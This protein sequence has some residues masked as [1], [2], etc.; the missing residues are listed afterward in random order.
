MTKSNTKRTSLLLILDGWG[1]REE[2]DSNA[3]AAA[4]TPTWDALW[5]A[6]PHT[7][8]TTSGMAVGLPEGQMGNSEVGHMNLGAGRV[9]YQSLT[10]I[11]KEIAEGGFFRNPVLVDVTQK[12]AT[13]GKALHLFGLLSPGGIHSHEQHM[14]AMIQLA[15]QQG[16]KKVYLHAFLDG[17]DMPP[18]SALPSLQLADEAL[19]QAGLGRIVSVIGRYFAMDRDKRWDRMQTAYDLMT[20]GEANYHADSVEQALS[21]AY[22]RGEDDE[23]VQATRVAATNDKTVT[24][25]D[26]DCVVFM[27]FRAD[28]ARQLTNAF[29]NPAF[30]GFVRKS[31]PALQS[32]V[33]LTEYSNDL[34]AFV[35]VAYGPQTL[36]NGLGEYLANHQRTQLRIAETE[37]YAHVT[38]FF[39]GGREEAFPGEDRILISSPSVATYDLKPEMSAFELTDKLEQAIRSGQYDAIICNYANGDMVGHTG[40]FDAAVKAVEALDQCLSRLVN[41]IHDVDGQCLITADH[42]NVEQMMDSSTGQ[43]LTSHTSGPVPLVYV[44][45]GDWHFTSEGSLSDIAPT[46]LTL[47]GMDVPAEMTGHVLISS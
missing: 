40:N 35:R 38:F 13:S 14:L 34:N 22:A 29:V 19:R 28:R 32:F 37:K 17:R 16:V 7:L 44:G 31:T 21:A 4:H 15:Q 9:V 33:T 26:G 46:L 10:M 43:P 11:D 24:M 36:N 3:I 12:V 2:T 5:K 6:C 27:N 42:G 1:Y 8:I 39:S 30:D 20:L 41:A 18:R 23:F 45:R 25:N 47:M